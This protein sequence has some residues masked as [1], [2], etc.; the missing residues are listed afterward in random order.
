MLCLAV[1]GTCTLLFYTN[2][3]SPVAPAKQLVC[4][5]E[6]ADVQAQVVTLFKKWH[7]DGVVWR[8]D[9]YEKEL[10]CIPSIQR[11]TIFR[12]LSGVW[13]VVVTLRR[14]WLQIENAPGY[15]IDKEGI[16]FFCSKWHSSVTLRISSTSQERHCLTEEEQSILQ[17]LV[18]QSWP[19][20]VTLHHIDTHRLYHSSIVQRAIIL[21]LHRPGG[22]DVLFLP[23]KNF[24]LA[25][26]RCYRAIAHPTAA[27]TR[28][29]DA[30]KGPILFLREEKSTGA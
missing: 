10:L 19:Q 17:Q 20:G 11:A 16:L 23:P 14:P 2:A 5:I 7:A 22:K 15:V 26:A 13:D 28:F 24:A 6:D 4:H 25:L 18:E 27:S 3:N 9:R 8:R 30:R 1:C 21:F 29:F 12:R